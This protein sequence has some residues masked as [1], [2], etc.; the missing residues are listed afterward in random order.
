MKEEDKKKIKEE[1]MK[2]R[3]LW[4]RRVLRYGPAII[5]FIGAIIK[6]FL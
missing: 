2:S 3:S 1:K 5:G 4:L 6:L